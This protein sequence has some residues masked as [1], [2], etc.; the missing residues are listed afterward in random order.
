MQIKDID[1]EVWVFG[2][3]ALIMLAL[4]IGIVLGIH[5]GIVYQREH[6]SATCPCECN[7]I[8]NED[9]I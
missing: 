2:A 3:C 7:R 6:P 8:M 9:P 5:D 1:M 4:I